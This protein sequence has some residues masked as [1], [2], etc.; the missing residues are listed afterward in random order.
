MILL[1][2]A[3]R[4]GGSHIGDTVHR[5]SSSA[6]SFSPVC[7][8]VAHGR[9]QAHELFQLVGRGRIKIAE[10]LE[11]LVDL[12]LRCTARTQLHSQREGAASLAL[13]A[14]SW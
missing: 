10:V 11:V 9:E 7:C 12:R 6:R 13:A 2:F 8:L 5:I 4:T 3:R 1:V 14:K